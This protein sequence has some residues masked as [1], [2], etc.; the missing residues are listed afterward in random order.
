MDRLQKEI[1]NFRVYGFDIDVIRLFI[2]P[3]TKVN[4]RNAKILAK[5]VFHTMKPILLEKEV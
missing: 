5:T 3:G 1:E 2:P 4:K